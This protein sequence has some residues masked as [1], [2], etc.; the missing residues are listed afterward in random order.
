MDMSLSRFLGGQ[1]CFQIMAEWVE[2]GLLR[3]SQ[4]TNVGGPSFRG[5]LRYVSF[6]VLEKCG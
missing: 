1:D 6:W 3:D 4:V 2:V 5:T